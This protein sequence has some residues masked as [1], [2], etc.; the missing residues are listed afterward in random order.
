MLF[1]RQLLL[2]AEADYNELKKALSA[3]IYVRTSEGVVPRLKHAQGRR[4]D[5]MMEARNSYIEALTALVAY[6]DSFDFP[7]QKLTETRDTVSKLKAE[8]A[9][10]NGYV[11]NQKRYIAAKTDEVVELVRTLLTLTPLCDQSKSEG[12]TAN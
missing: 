3:E 4:K 1:R 7:I 8:M 2:T 12:L 6:E 11:E 10:I 9:E 5:T